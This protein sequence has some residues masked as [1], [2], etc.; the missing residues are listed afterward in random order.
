LHIEHLIIFSHGCN[1]CHELSQTRHELHHTIKQRITTT[2]HTIFNDIYTQIL[3]CI[4][5]HKMSQNTS[6]FTSIIQESNNL[7]LYNPIYTKI[8][9][10]G[11]IRIHTGSTILDSG[12][13][14]NTGG[15]T[16][17]SWRSRINCS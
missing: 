11:F 13:N 16:I 6:Q 2:T 7:I 1:F 5:R 17:N 10:S 15:S 4:L 12:R 8:V 14:T 9:W 3:G